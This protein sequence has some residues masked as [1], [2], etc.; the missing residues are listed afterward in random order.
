MN[1]WDVSA[2]KILL[3]LSEQHTKGKMLNFDT[4]TTLFVCNKWDQ[5]GEDEEE[6]VLTSIKD[7]LISDWP[8]VDPGQQLF[9]M[10]CK[11]VCV[12]F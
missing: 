1:K 5:V 8:N 3:N 10:S 7:K 9:K 2:K 4:E 6:A 11:K 12:L